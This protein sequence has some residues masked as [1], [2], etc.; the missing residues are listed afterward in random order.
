MTEE[1]FGKC[2]V[3]VQIELNQLMV[4]LMANFVNT[5]MND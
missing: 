1:M 4:S 3:M 2:G 5:A